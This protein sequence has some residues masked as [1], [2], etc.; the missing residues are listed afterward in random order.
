MLLG[1]ADCRPCDLRP[2]GAAR[3]ERPFFTIMA[4]R[5]AKLKLDTI[6]PIIEWRIHLAGRRRRLTWQTD[7]PEPTVEGTSLRA[8]GQPRRKTAGSDELPDLQP[9]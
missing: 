4:C 8:V 7:L 1:I 6:K 2:L 5:T 9:L 3:M